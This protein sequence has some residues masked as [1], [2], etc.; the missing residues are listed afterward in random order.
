V[1][2]YGVSLLVLLSVGGCRAESSAPDDAEEG[3]A[4]WSSE[5]DVDWKTADLAAR[6]SALAYENREDIAAKLRDIEPGARFAFFEN[7]RTDTQAI[8]VEGPRFITVA[9]RGTEKKSADVQSDVQTV[10]AKSVFG[11]VHGGFLVAL[12]SVWM[13]DGLGLV[14][15]GTSRPGE[16]I[17]SYL[18]AHP[19]RR[20]LFTGHSLGGAMATIASVLARYQQCVAV[21]LPF[22]DP[23]DF[24][25]CAYHQVGRRAIRLDVAPAYTFGAPR[26]GDPQFGEIAAG[27]VGE[28]RRVI[29]FVE[30]D[31]PV[32]RLPYLG[33]FAHPMRDHDEH[34]TEVLLSDRTIVPAISAHAIAHYIDGIEGIEKQR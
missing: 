21:G 25:S 34:S 33:G 6:L 1:R 29:R 17:E 24:E 12:G 5:T 2:V 15:S 30:G 8:A 28:P 13:D 11:G 16:G 10:M 20:I 18:L 23:H 26:P 7:T 14:S 4:A 31:D 19:D 22:R 9:F 27:P 32:P 3:N